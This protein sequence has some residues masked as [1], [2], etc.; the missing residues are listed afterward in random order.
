MTSTPGIPTPDGD[1]ELEQL[2][3][4]SEDELVAPEESILQREL[5]PEPTDPIGSEEWDDSS[6]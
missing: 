4:E 6:D 5:R 2:E 3:S 1:D